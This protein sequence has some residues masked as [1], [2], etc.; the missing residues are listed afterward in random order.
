MTDSAIV[1]LLI[2]DNF[3]EIFKKLEKTGGNLYINNIINKWLLS[4]FIQGISETY[5]NFIWD[6]FLL[7]GNLIIFKAIYAIFINLE[8]DLNQYKNFDELNKIFNKKPLEL[9]NRGKLAYYLIAKQFNFNMEIINKYRK[10]LSPQIIKEVINI[11]SFKNYEEEDEIKDNKNKIV[12]DLDWPEC[13]KD[14]KNL[15]KEYDFVVL[16]ELEEPNVIQD[17]ID[18]Y[19]EYKNGSKKI[20][21]KNYNKNFIND[22]DIE[23][24][25]IKYFK[26]ERF[27]NLLIERKKHFCGSNLMSIRSCFGKS[28]KNKS[29]KEDNKLN[30]KNIKKYFNENDKDESLKERNRRI[31]RIVTQVS[32]SNQNKISFVKENNENNFF[33]D[34]DNIEK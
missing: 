27:K 21:K 28:E 30:I 20:E 14:K 12:C 16:K 15:E 10:A 25:K 31:N 8:Q 11:G 17:Y 13:I 1:N 33:V 2:K 29:D 18:C 7:E 26:E 6:L 5:S 4:I 23:S 3:K 22:D 34:D 9:N 19:K 32:K 24:Q